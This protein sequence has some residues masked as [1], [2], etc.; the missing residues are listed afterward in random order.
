MIE[1][2]RGA[3]ALQVPKRT[4]TRSEHSQVAGLVRFVRLTSSH[5]RRMTVDNGVHQAERRPCSP[6]FWGRLPNALEAVARETQRLTIHE[7]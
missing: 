2:G 7:H 3:T 5:M 4:K 6:S 1:L